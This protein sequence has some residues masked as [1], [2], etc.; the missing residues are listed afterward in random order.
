MLW[1]DQEG[2][3]K[4]CTYSNGLL[5][6]GDHVNFPKVKVKGI[7]VGG[8]VF[9]GRD[10]HRPLWSPVREELEAYQGKPWDNIQHL[11][12]GRTKYALLLIKQA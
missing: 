6:Q 10:T 2:Y 3:S 7:I 4:V 8:I 12:H 11:Y 9:E 5:I 1:P